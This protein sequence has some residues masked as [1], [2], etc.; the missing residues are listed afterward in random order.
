M[1][2]EAKFASVRSLRPVVR[3][4]FGD[5]V[6]LTGVERLAGGSKKGAYV[7]RL[8]DASGH[9]STALVYVWDPAEDYWDG[10]LPAEV[11]DPAEPFAHASGLELFE[12]AANRLT[13]VGVRCPR[14]VFADRSRELYPADIAVV[15]HVPGGSLQA[16]MDADPQAAEP[17]LDVLAGWLDAMAAYQAPMFGKVAYVD[18]ADAGSQPASAGGPRAAASCMETVLNRALAEVAEVAQRDARMAAARD[19]LEALLHELAAPIGPRATSALIH[20]ELG[21]D[22]VLIDAAG[23]PVLIDIEGLMYFDVEWEHVFLRLRFGERYR[24]FA[25]PGLDVQ[26]LRLYQLA[27]HIDLVA[28]PLGIADT[29][30]PERDWFRE[31]A[32]DHLR[33]ALEYTPTTVWA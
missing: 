3:A 9:A 4:A 7:A 1:A 23:Q 20:G 22:H 17:A 33:R 24:H 5:G 30:H 21:P 8:S 13:A 16:L 6:R 2:D 28:G 25:R 10:V 14:I 31:L 29:G 26:R 19:R 18:A 27:Q 32:E 11:A 15:E 12:A